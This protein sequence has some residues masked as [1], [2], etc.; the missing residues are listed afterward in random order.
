MPGA[1]IP[2]N[3]Q[4]S[5]LNAQ[6]PTLNAQR[7][8]QEERNHAGHGWS[9]IGRDLALNVGRNKIP[10]ALSLF[11]PCTSVPSVV[12]IQVPAAPFQFSQKF[13]ER[14]KFGR[15]DSYEPAMDHRSFGNHSSFRVGRLSDQTICPARGGGACIWGFGA[16]CLC[17]SPGSPRCGGLPF[18][19][20]SAGHGTDRGIVG[21]SGGAA[22]ST[23]GPDAGSGDCHRGSADA[24]PDL[25][26]RHHAG[27]GDDAGAWRGDLRAAFA[28]HLLR[29]FLRAARHSSGA[30]WKIGR[31]GWRRTG[32]R[33]GAFVSGES[34]RKVRL[35]NP[36]IPF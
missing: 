9:R 36:P 2:V 3:F 27:G 16:S 18:A 31:I 5:T 34:G 25:G 19:K 29:A 30:G 13:D 35:S 17:R 12:E 23:G 32:S 1:G 24:D 14:R 10:P 33:H 22:F 7:L 8:R 26:D 15:S 20:G 4:R 6:R 21:D 28:G 11:N